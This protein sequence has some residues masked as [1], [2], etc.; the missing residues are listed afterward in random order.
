MVNKGV[1]LYM[2]LHQED[3]ARNFKPKQSHKLISVNSGGF[4]FKD[5]ELCSW[6][7]IVDPSEHL[8]GHANKRPNS[9]FTQ[10]LPE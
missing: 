3:A 5:A 8:D 1:R 10:H 2:S 9:K 7:V 4:L 6:V